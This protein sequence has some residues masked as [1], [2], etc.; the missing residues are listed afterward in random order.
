MKREDVLKAIAKGEQEWGKS[1]SCETRAHLRETY[2]ADAILELEKT[3]AEPEWVQDLKALTIHKS[4]R[5]VNHQ[6]AINGIPADKFMIDFFG[7]ELKKLK[8]EILT[9]AGSRPGIVEAF[10]KRGIK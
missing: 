3:E 9:C 7:T 4:P 10:E 8:F 2:I 5:D 1:L 6:L